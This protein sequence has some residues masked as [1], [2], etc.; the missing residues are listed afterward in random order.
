M[1]EIW[2]E[3]KGFENYQISNLGR[4]KNIKYHRQQKSQILKP[5]YKANGYLSIT[6]SRNGKTNM[7]YIHRLVASHFV[8]NKEDKP[9]V[10]HKDGC[11]N[12]NTAENLEWVTFS[13]NTKHSYHKLGY[14]I[15]EE[16][17]QKRVQA[18]KKNYVM[19]GETKKKIG[20]SNRK[21]SC[22]R[23]L[24]IELNKEFSSAAMASEWL[25]LTKKVVC[26]ACRNNTTSGGYHWTYIGE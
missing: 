9:C 3:I 11:R 16:T 21:N 25:G 5:H 4:I 22:K 10:N 2:K 26:R 6:L 18:F 15:S 1:E 12:N 23:V 20:E 14:K 24:C 19:S 7:F 17:I 13:E 8:D